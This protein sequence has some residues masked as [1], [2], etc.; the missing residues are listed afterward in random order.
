MKKSKHTIVLALLLLGMSLLFSLE[1]SAQ[2]YIEYYTPTATATPAGSYYYVIT[3]PM[4]HDN[5]V[6][7]WQFSKGMDGK[8]VQDISNITV[9]EKGASTEIKFNTSAGTTTSPA[10]GYEY[11]TSSLLIVNPDFTYLKV[12]SGTAVPQYRLLT[13]KPTTVAFEPNKTYVVTLD[14]S[15]TLDN[16]TTRTF[17]ANNNNILQHVYSFEFQT[18]SDDTDAD[19]IAD[20]ADNCP[21]VCNPQQLDSDGDSTGDACDAAPGCGGCGQAACEESCDIDNDGVRNAVDNCPN[22]YNPQQLD[23]DTDGTG[24]CCDTYPGCGGCGLGDCDQQC[25]L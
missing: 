7:S 23:A 19:G 24:D 16:G 5:I 18:A 1:A 21:T 3:N 14:N 11:D 12:G 25:S 20:S 6:L 8:F 13:L 2:M 17:Q 4:P 22:I 9:K 10:P 15:T